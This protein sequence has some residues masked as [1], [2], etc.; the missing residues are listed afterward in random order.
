VLP[1]GEIKTLR[2][3]SGCAN[4]A[5][6]VVY[7]RG[8]NEDG[9]GEEQIEFDDAK[10]HRQNADDDRKQRNQQPVERLTSRVAHAAN[11]EP[12][13]KKKTHENRSQWNL[14]N[15]VHGKRVHGKKRP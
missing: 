2:N 11:H 13:L 15:N 10:S 1:S 9:V 3:E 5:D 4:H 8:D 12:T 14:G 6:A 7:V